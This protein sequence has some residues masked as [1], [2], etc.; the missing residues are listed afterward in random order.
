MKKQCIPAQKYALLATC[1]LAG[2]A[3]AQ[4]I[5]FRGDTMPM[6]DV[7]GSYSGSR[8]IVG[9]TGVG[10]LD[11]LS[12]A[13][14]TTTVYASIGRQA[15][16]SGSATIADGSLW[17]TNRMV[18]GRASTG[19]VTIKNN[20]S[21]T[22]NDYLYIG[23]LPGGH[24]TVTVDGPG[25]S[26]TTPA[27]QRRQFW[28]GRRGGSGTLRVLNGATVSPGHIFTAIHTGSTSFIEVDGPGS[29]L[30]VERQCNLGITGPA[31]M[32][33]THGG[34]V[35]CG[36]MADLGLGSVS[37]SGT[38]S[39][40]TVLTN[41]DIGRHINS[42]HGVLKI[43]EGSAVEV[44]N[45]LRLPNALTITTSTG[46]GELHIE[47]ATL[48]GA[49]R[50]AGLV[51]GI[52]GLGRIYFNHS[53]ASG[54]YL[55]APPISGPGTVYANGSGTTNL[56]GSNVYAGSTYVN[57]GVLRAGAATGLSPASDYVVAAGGTLD[58]GS[59]SA[60]LRSLDNAG[61]VTLLSAGTQAVLT[62]AN[63]YSAQNGVMALNTA[64]GDSSSPTAKLVVQGDTSGSTML[65]INNLGGA[66][67]VTTGDGILVV[68]VDG[69][70][71]GRFSLPAPGHLVAG[72]FRYTLAQVGPH[73]YLQSEEHM[74]TLPPEASVVCSPGELSDTAN[75]VST[76]TVS[77]SS[78]PTTDLPIDLRLPAAH[79]RYT[80]TCTS[81]LVVAAH[82][83]QASCTIT[84]TPNTTA[85][86]G[87]V[88]AELAVAPPGSADAYTPAGP[89]AQV[90]IKDAGATQQPGTL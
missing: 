61:T 29:R 9:N 40:W 35:Q 39:T 77:L 80:T 5:E 36:F 37:L 24:G 47:G 1:L 74:K 25:S 67:A 86:D 41:L 65:N 69:A 58:T 28:I 30:E 3:Q 2:L 46:E 43:G 42:S 57:A 50:A 88:T 54:D 12:G 56:T 78:A 81:P 38:G 31:T 8:V 84:A 6:G 82:A 52:N 21:V 66:G 44:S 4:R 15:G 76:C 45:A 16:A 68:Q 89:A 59:Y 87:D 83:T 63:D 22:T 27:Q 73:W 34:T 7:G 17:N 48:P 62:V 33:I 49:L 26:W 20:A 70:S 14:L 23:L 90:L 19:A 53:D 32:H 64:L 51:L 85:G 72:G 10:S 71:N 60:T 11:V 55:F 79:P 75:Q 13:E 18:I